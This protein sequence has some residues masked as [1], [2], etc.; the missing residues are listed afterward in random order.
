MTAHTNWLLCV[1]FIGPTLTSGPHFPKPSWHV[2]AKVFIL[3]CCVL[4]LSS[5]AHNFPIALEEK[6]LCTILTP[7]AIWAE[8]DINARSVLHG[9]IPTSW[10]RHLHCII[11]GAKILSNSS[12]MKTFLVSSLAFSYCKHN[13]CT[14]LWLSAD[15]AAMVRID[16]RGWWAQ[17]ER[18]LMWFNIEYRE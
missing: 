5:M 1:Q 6:P 18:P 12:R 3:M 15:N 9:W 2:V 7:L 10:G 17:R 13:C 4:G 14:R 11:I 16:S 8:A